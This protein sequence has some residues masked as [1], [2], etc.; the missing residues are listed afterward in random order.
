MRDSSELLTATEYVPL[1]ESRACSPSSPGPLPPSLAC[2]RPGLQCAARPRLQ[3][4]AL[5]LH[6]VLMPHALPDTSSPPD[7]PPPDQSFSPLL[8]TTTR[9]PKLHHLLRFP[10]GLT[11]QVYLGGRGRAVRRAAAD[12]SSSK[13]QAGSGLAARSRR[14]GVFASRDERQRRKIETNTLRRTHPTRTVASS[15]L[16][17]DAAWS[18][19]CQ[20]L[21]GRPAAALRVTGRRP[22]GGGLGKSGCAGAALQK[23]AV[24]LP[25]EPGLSC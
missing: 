11:P 5:P 13:A 4:A 9:T 14:A 23:A 20:P 16:S 15:R 1:P 25:A 7:S 22:G 17:G 3:C 18:P 2:A 19:A 8:P 24:S 21:R 6:V 12:G 10:P